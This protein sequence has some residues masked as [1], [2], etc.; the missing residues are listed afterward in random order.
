M[1]NTH[2]III[3]CIS[4]SYK[5]VI[6]I[7]TSFEIIYNLFTVFVCF[8]SIWKELNNVKRDGDMK[9]FAL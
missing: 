1:H 5:A 4:N 9:P 6:S 3:L 2:M 8:L 7:K